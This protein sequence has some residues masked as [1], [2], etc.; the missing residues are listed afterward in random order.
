MQSLVEA[1]MECNVETVR[2]RTLRYRHHGIWFD[3]RAIITA[4]FTVIAAAKS[5]RVVVAPQWEDRIKQAIATLAF[6][7]AE[8]P[9]LQKS[10][11]LLPELF[12]ETRGLIR[13]NAR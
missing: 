5:G 11:E 3:I 13:A 6:W 7:E 8:S 12:A 2:N 10:R 4:S 9:D 1:A